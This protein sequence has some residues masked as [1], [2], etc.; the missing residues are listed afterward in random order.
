ME[1]RLTTF[2]SGSDADVIVA[3][4]L[5]APAKMYAIPDFKSAENINPLHL[6]ARKVWKFEMW[7]FYIKWKTERT[8]TREAEVGV[9]HHST[10]LASLAAFQAGVIDKEQLANDTV[11][12]KRANRA[13]HVSSEVQKASFRPRLTWADCDP[14]DSDGRLDELLCGNGIV[15]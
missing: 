14:C 15:R 4:R 11:V 9:S 1:L 8:E 2:R 5:P 6:Y 3:G 13:R 7:E 12:N 10:R